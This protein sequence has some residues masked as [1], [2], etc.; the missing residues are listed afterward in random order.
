VTAGNIS[1]LL[2]ACWV[3]GLTTTIPVFMIEYELI[4]YEIYYKYL[5]LSL[6][7]IIMVTFVIT[8]TY[9]LI[10]KNRQEKRCRSSST[11]SQN[12]NHQKFFI[13]CFLIITSFIVF[14]VIP[15]I[16]FVNRQVINGLWNNKVEIQAVD[17][18]WTINNIMSPLIYIFFQT[19][20]RNSLTKKVRTAFMK[21][22]TLDVHE[23]SEMCSYISV[24]NIRE[25]SEMNNNISV[26]TIPETTK[27][28]TNI[29]VSSSVF[30]ITY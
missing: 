26:S 30:Y 25:T 29:S 6:D 27:K 24:S 28:S 14:Y 19:D 1:K 2:L 20:I 16:Y 7:S 5:F 17:A 12:A 18:L 3:V 23:A 22:R 8:Y 9:I 11:F 15:D 10:K 4:Y 13:V 21:R